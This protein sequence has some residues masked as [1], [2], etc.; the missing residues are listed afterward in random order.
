MPIISLSKGVLHHTTPL[1]V[2]ECLAAEE[3][4]E[5]EKLAEQEN[6]KAESQRS[7]C[8]SSEDGERLDELVNVAKDAKVHV[9]AF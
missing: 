7:Q 3:Q 1:Q 5:E 8:D 6:E 2:A 9:F 4:N